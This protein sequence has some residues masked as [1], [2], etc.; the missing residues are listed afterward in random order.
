M[1]G[2]A[3]ERREH[4]LKHAVKVKDTSMQ[5]DLIAAAAEEAAIKFFKL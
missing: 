2:D 4:R 5:W 1:M 3:L